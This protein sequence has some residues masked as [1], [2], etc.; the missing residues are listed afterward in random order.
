MTESSGD[1][2]SNAGVKSR[3]KARKKS[4]AERM[5]CPQLKQ[6]YYF[7]KNNTVSAQVWSVADVFALTGISH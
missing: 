2:A 4:W 1:R 6:G 3:P 5:A 7:W